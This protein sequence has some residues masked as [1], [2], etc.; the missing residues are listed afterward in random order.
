[1]DSVDMATRLVEVLD[2]TFRTQLGRLQESL[3]DPVVVINLLAT[4]PSSKTPLSYQDMCLLATFC[5]WESPV[6]FSGNVDDNKTLS[7]WVHEHYIDKGSDSDI[8]K[9]LA[10]ASA[11][12]ESV[13]A[14]PVPG[15]SNSTPK[16]LFPED[17]GSD[18]QEVGRTLEGSQAEEEDSE[19]GEIPVVDV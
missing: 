17:E 14:V 9:A 19:T 4:N 1:M 8:L 7:Q 5:K 16:P 13:P 18:T 6:N 10:A 12:S 15:P 3:N 2:T 11:E